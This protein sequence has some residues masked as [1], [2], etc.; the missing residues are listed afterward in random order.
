MEPWFDTNS[1]HQRQ[2]WK[3]TCGLD[4]DNIY[5]NKQGEFIGG[6]Q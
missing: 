6:S 3:F 1:S 4:G 2:K 5:F